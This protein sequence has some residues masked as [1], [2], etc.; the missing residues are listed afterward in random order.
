MPKPRPK[1]SSKRLPAWL[2]PQVLVFSLAS[3]LTDISSEMVAPFMPLFV[4]AVLGGGALALGAID[5]VAEAVAAVLKLEAGRWSDRLGKRRP[6]VVGGYALSG[7]ARPLM[8]LVGSVWTAGLV[9]STDRIGKGL[10]TS[11]RDAL[12]AAAVPPKEQGRAFGLHRAFDHTG[13]TLG[14]LLALV[15]LYYFGRETGNLRRIFLWGAVPGVFAFLLLWAFV[16]E[17]EKSPSANG[18][19]L[20]RA[21]MPPKSLRPFMAALTVF[22]LGASTDLFLIMHVAP[23]EPKDAL[24]ATPLLWIGLHIVKTISS[25]VGGQISDRLGA[26]PTLAFGWLLYAA[27]YAALAFLHPGPLAI[28]VLLVYG[29]YY[30]LTEGP[31]KVLVTR[32]SAAKDRAEAFG[33]YHLV[34]GLGALPASL[35]FGGLYQYVGPRAAFLTGAGFALAGLLLLAATPPAKG[36]R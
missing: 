31:E 36:K 2:G 30:G 6:F 29:V 23:S 28:A 25:I 8:G 16:R 24:T 27:V 15:L 4:T 5:G 11:P 20:P 9:R 22:T 10:R 14:P 34:T 18:K 33:W 12:L 3:L 17:A 19:A 1:P 13:A 26:R 32:L 21:W 7:L 35:L